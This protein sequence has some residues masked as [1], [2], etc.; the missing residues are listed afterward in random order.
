MKIGD[1]VEWDTPSRVRHAGAVVGVLPASVPLR[2][3]T[4]ADH[5]WYSWRQIPGYSDAMRNHESYIV[6]V[7]SEGKGKGRTYWPRVTAL[8]KVDLPT[9][10]TWGLGG[11]T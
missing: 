8:R 11:R 5:S 1:A 9:D 10:V 6:H 2:Y 7:P 4:F 3:V